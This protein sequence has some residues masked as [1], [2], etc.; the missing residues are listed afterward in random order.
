MGAFRSLLDLERAT[1]SPGGI[2]RL[3]AVVTRE[4]AAVAAVAIKR[5]TEFPNIR[6]GIYPARRL[7][8]EL[9]QLLQREIFFFGQKLDA[10]FVGQ[11]HGG[12]FRSSLLARQPSFTVIANTDAAFGS[13][14]RAIPKDVGAG[15]FILAHNIW[16]TTGAFHF[17]ERP[18]FFR[19]AFR[20]AQAGLHFGPL[21]ILVAVHVF[22]K[23]GLQRAEQPF[24][25]F[26]GQLLFHFKRLLMD[27]TAFMDGI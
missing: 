18:Q 8:V 3:R 11:I 1:E 19:I 2:V 23:A 14:R 27:G 25:L 17:M 26:W 12:G 22:L 10:H 24:A 15:L 5:S 20:P 13:F 16:F 7:L 6:R 21:E 4:D 9:A